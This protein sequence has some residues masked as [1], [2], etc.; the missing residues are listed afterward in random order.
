MSEW[1]NKAKIDAREAGADIPLII[2]RAV[3]RKM[4]RSIDRVN[5]VYVCKPDDAVGMVHVLRQVL[6][7][8]MGRKVLL[9][10][11]NTAAEMLYDE[12]TSPSGIARL[13]ALFDGY[14]R[15]INQI[16]AEKRASDLNFRKRETE[17][18]NFFNAL[19]DTVSSIQM[20]V[21]SDSVPQLTRMMEP[22]Q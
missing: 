1:T 14:Q 21:G 2:T 18:R 20:A 7:M 5:G 22:P 17:A 13:Q 16:Q 19:V 4:T 9:E 3:P 10:A 15:T 8:S 12:I 11:R 6:I